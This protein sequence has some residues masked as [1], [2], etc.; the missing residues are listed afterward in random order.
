MYHL[1]LFTSAI[2]YP[3]EINIA[4]TAPRDTARAEVEVQVDVY[5]EDGIEINEVLVERRLQRVND[6]RVFQPLF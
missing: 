4:E 1:I 2:L 6:I 5:V 3:V